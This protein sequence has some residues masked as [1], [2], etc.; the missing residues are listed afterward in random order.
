MKPSGNKGEVSNL[1]VSVKDGSSL[2]KKPKNNILQKVTA[3]AFNIISRTSASE[4]VIGAWVFDKETVDRLKA[5]CDEVDLLSFR[6][7]NYQKM[8]TSF[9]ELCYMEDK[10]Q[11]KFLT[12]NKRQFL[13]YTYLVLPSQ[14]GTFKRHGVNS[15]EFFRKFDDFFMTPLQYLSLHEIDIKTEY[16]NCE[17]IPKHEVGDFSKFD[18][19]LELRCRGLGLEKLIISP[20]ARIDILDCSHNQLQELVL[21]PGNLNSHLNCSYNFKGMRSLNLEDQ[22][23]LFCLDA[24]NCLFNS[25]RL[26]TDNSRN[27]YER[28]L[29]INIEGN[30]L[31]TLDLAGYDQITI[32][33]DDDIR[34]IMPVLKYSDEDEDEN[35][36]LERR[37]FPI[38]KEVYLRNL[39]KIPVNWDINW[40]IEFIPRNDN[41]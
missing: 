17:G 21:F 22:P 41:A 24:R 5:L 37:K 8:A 4:E 25:V 12:L 18:D 7:C 35:K 20:N 30:L 40:D 16:L 33:C 9:L 3:D 15:D 38:N 31:G 23:G 19:L 32:S 14:R 34:L 6:D 39:E 1:P 36:I 28:E 2:Q 29:F 27:I 13:T 10:P 26:D 11:D